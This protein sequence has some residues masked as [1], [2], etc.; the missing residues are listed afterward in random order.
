MAPL[1]RN[2]ARVTLF[3][4][5]M[6]SAALLAL[7]GCHTLKVYAGRLVVKCGDSRYAL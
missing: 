4:V 1:I 6:A 3:A 2:G 5:V 7:S